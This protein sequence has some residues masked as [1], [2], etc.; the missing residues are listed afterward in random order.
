VLTDLATAQRRALAFHEDDLPF[1]HEECVEWDSPRFLQFHGRR[2]ALI[3]AVSLKM[4]FP[5]PGDKEG[6]SSG[7]GF[8][9]DLAWVAFERETLDGVGLYLGR[10]AVPPA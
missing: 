10:V 5:L 8:S 7:H 4:S 9:P 1:A 3:D 2:V 6:E